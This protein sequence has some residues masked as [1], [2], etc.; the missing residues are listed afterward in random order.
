MVALCPRVSMALVV[1][2]LGIAFYF[3]LWI[4]EWVVMT[5]VET[6]HPR[7]E[8]HIVSSGNLERYFEIMDE[9]PA[10]FRN[11]DGQNALHLVLDKETLREKQQALQNIGAYMNRPPHYYTLGVLGE[12][13]L[14]FFLRDL[15]RYPEGLLLPCERHVYKMKLRGRPCVV[16]VPHTEGKILLTRRFS[17]Y[18]RQWY[19]VTPFIC[20]HANEG[21]FDIACLEVLETTGYQTANLIP[22]FNM[23]EDDTAVFIAEVVKLDNANPVHPSGTVGESRWFS[24]SELEREILRGAVTDSAILATY[25]HL[26]RYGF[27]TAAEPA[28]G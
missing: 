25:I 1:A 12:D 11:E 22:L 13:E 27:K 5:N 3:C 2:T 21:F 4:Y 18:Y 16:I 7:K 10:L 26:L 23:S 14:Q 6:P 9:Y 15:V 19:W 28:A 17:R 24:L 8:T 20:L